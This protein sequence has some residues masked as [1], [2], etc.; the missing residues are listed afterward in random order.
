MNKLPVIP[1]DLLDVLDAKFPEKCPEV[2][3]SDREIW[4]KVGQRSVVRHLL[5]IYEQQNE[6]ILGEQHVYGSE[7]A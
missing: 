6:N 1:K 5:K 4:I 7:D 3:W 2:N